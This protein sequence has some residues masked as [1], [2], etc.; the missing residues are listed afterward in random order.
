MIW[1]R[2]WKGIRGGIY[3]SGRPVPGIRL[4]AVPSYDAYF[5]ETI[6][7]GVSSLAHLVGGP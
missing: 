2:C 4:L 3:A 6:V 7:G 1:I 5:F